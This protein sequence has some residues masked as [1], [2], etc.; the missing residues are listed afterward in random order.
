MYTI[1]TVI[2]IKYK[3]VVVGFITCRNRLNCRSTVKP[4][5]CV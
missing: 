2:L 5:V 3:T 4:L 1:D